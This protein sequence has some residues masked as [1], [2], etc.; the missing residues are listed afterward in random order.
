[1]TRSG[2]KETLPYDPEIERTIRRLG[3]Q[4]TRF[5]ETAEAESAQEAHPIADPPSESSESHHQA[6]KMVENMAQHAAHAGHAV[7]YEL[8][9][10][11]PAMRAPMPRERT[12]RELAAPISDQA[13]L[14]ITYPPLTVPFELKTSLIHLLPKFRG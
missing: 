12:M 4:A 3:K 7:H 8:I 5:W 13:P 2:H 1:M 9:Q 14:C 6:T 10:E 11:N